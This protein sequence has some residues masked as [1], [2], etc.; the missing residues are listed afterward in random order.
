MTGVVQLLTYNSYKP[1][2]IRQIDCST[3]IH[4]GRRS[5]EIEAVELDSETYSPGETLQGTVFVRPYKGLRQRLPVSLKL[6]ADLPEGSYTAVV[7]DDLY[8]ARQTLRDNPNLSSPQSLEQVFQA[9]EVQTAV[10]RTNL[11]VRVPVNE[12]GVAL[13]GKSLPN[14][15]PSMVQILGN[16]RRTGAQPMSGALVSKQHTNWVVQGTDSVRFTVTKNKK[17]LAQQ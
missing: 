10:K 3:R 13:G 7:C 8:N 1:V 2:R 12:I 6:P 4:S 14:L 16:T 11:V 5:A 17:V 15:P 9:L